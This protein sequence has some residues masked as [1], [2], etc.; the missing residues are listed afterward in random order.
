M[1][2]N[3]EKNVFLGIFD[4][5]QQESFDNIVYSH[6]FTSESK[7]I[8][9]PFYVSHCENDIPSTDRREAL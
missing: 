1:T 3:H 7:S 9:H 8:L 4:E 5:S 2:N 6:R